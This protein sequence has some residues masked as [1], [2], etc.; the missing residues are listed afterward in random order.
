M[1]SPL[2][3]PASDDE[4]PATRSTPKL[5]VLIPCWN[6]ADTIERAMTSILDAQGIALEC[7]VIDDGSTDGTF[8]IAQRVAD[9]DPRVVLVRL[10]TNEGVSSARNHGLAV[11]RG[12]WLAFLDADDRLLPGAVAALMRPTADPDVL[13]VIGQRIWTDGERSWLSTLYDIPDIR[14]PGRKAIGTHPGLLY[15]A[16]A[17]GKVFH[18]SLVGGRRFEGRV[19]GDQPWTI[20][21]LLAASDRIE[22]IEDTVYE[23]HRP[24]PH[25]YV[26]TITAETRTSARSAAEMASVARTAFLE[27]SDDVDALVAVEARRPIVKRTYFERLLRS[28]IGDRLRVAADRRDPATGAFYEAVGRFFESVPAAILASTDVHL[29]QVVRSASYRFSAFTPATR[30]SY[31]RMIRPVL[32]RDPRSSRQIGGNAVFGAAFWLARR[33]RPSIGEALA[34]AVLL[35]ASL[36]ARLVR[37]LG[38]A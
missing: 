10:V 22:V 34:G 7:V 12:D 16:S 3:G 35:P 38:L 21:A 14:E 31:W 13:A 19:L 20:H 27:V 11:A 4:V 23:W 18:R 24:H 6:A 36:A 33:F 25:R 32:S 37:R 28:D 17:T 5:S 29:T 8:D 26:P 1:G 30:S 9:R 2:I 15:Y